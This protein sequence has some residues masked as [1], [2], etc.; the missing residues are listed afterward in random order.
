MVVVREAEAA[1]NR[2]AIE[3]IGKAL[4]H[5]RAGRLDEAE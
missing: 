5:Y 3:V 4:Q 1:G 2:T